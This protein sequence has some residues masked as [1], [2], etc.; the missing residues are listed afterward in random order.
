M[1][2]RSKGTFKI[3]LSGHITWI[4]LCQHQ[5]VMSALKATLPKALKELR[6]HFC[7][8]SPGS[9]GI[10]YY[11]IFNLMRLGLNE[12]RI[13]AVLVAHNVSMYSIVTSALLFL[14]NMS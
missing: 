1:A 8:T 2:H 13:T 10:R 3:E 5:T 9:S 6:I 4:A 12:C 14:D 7:Q 11:F